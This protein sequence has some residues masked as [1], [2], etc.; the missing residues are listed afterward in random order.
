MGGSPASGKGSASSS[1]M[2]WRLDD[3][4]GEGVFV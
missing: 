1:R 4:P 3:R 2:W